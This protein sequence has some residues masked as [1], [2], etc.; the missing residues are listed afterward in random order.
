MSYDAHFQKEK[1]IRQYFIGLQAQ[2]HGFFLNICILFNLFFFFF[3]CIKT[4]FNIV[5]NAPYL[6]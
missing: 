6:V 3:K 2:V 4:S 5:S 1:S